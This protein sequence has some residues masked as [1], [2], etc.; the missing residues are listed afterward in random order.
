MLQQSYK[1]YSRTNYIN[2]TI[3]FLVSNIYTVVSS[4]LGHILERQGMRGVWSKKGNPWK[5]AILRFLECENAKK[6]VRNE[7][8]IVCKIR[9]SNIL[10]F[11]SSIFAML[12]LPGVKVD[13]SFYS[14]PDLHNVAI[15]VIGLLNHSCFSIL[16]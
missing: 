9:P 2:I 4:R 5:F 3:L 16:V 15:V 7:S 6:N 1:S 8:K 12:T 14:Q 10:T 13:G 11:I